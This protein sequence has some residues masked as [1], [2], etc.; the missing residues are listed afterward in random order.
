MGKAWHVSFSNRV[1]GDEERR[2]RKGE[3]NQRG[4]H[5]WEERGAQGEKLVFW[6]RPWTKT[7]RDDI[8]TVNRWLQPGTRVQA[9]H[10]KRHSGQRAR[11]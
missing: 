6:V 4:P 5:K 9:A 2:G 7:G 10:N 8:S 1:W 3:R 11:P